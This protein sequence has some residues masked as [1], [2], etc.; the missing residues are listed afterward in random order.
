VAFRRKCSPTPALVSFQPR[1]LYQE[2]RCK[3]SV[4]YGSINARYGSVVFALKNLPNKK[5]LPAWFQI[6]RRTAWQL[7]SDE[8]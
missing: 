1:A 4:S 7:T 6:Y 5:H 2:N 8:S 3:L